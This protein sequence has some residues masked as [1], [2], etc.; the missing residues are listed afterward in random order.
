[1]DE[2][3]GVALREL[4]V[5]ALRQL[6]AAREPDCVL[7]VKVLGMALTLALAML[8]SLVWLLGLA[9]ALKSS[10]V[11]VEMAAEAVPI[12]N[13]LLMPQLMARSVGVPVAVPKA[14][15]A[16]GARGRARVLAP[17]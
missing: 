17:Q 5:K 1:M 9:V 16:D 4:V 10:R 13:L 8:L 2:P 15:G 7:L 12:A 6:L 11:K 3:G 14:S